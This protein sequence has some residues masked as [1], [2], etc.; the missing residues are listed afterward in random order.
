M[1]KTSAWRYA[2][3]RANFPVIRKARVDYLLEVIA[4]AL[5]SE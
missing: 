5:L 4:Q 2:G 3:E 1:K